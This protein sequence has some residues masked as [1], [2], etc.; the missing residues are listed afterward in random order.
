[1]P[2]ILT[3]SRAARTVGGARREALTAAPG[4]PLRVPVPPGFRWIGMVW[5]VAT[6]FS[7]LVPEGEIPMAAFRFRSRLRVA[8]VAT[9][10]LALLVTAMPVSAGGFMT[11]IASGYSLPLYVTNAGDSRLFV[12]EQRGRI[13]IIGGGT[14]LDLSGLVSQT[15]YERGLLGLAFHPD[16]ASNGRLYVNY[17]RQ[18]DG[19]TMIV[20][21][22]RSAGNPNAADPASARTVLSF[23][24][25]DA[26][27]NGGWMGFKGSNLFIS[28]GDGGDAGDGGARAQSTSYLLGKILR[29]N[30]LDPDGNG[31]KR[32][33]IPSTNPYVGISGLNEIWARGLRNPWRCSH[34]R[35]T[36]YLWCADV[37]QQKYEEINR[38]TSG[39]KLNYG[40][41]LLEGRH[42]YPSG[43]LCTSSCKTL[44]IAEYSHSAF[45]GGNCAVTGGYVSRR[46]G[47]S[48]NGRYFFGDFCSGK[49]WTIGA[50]FS[51]GGSLPS[52]TVD[53]S[54]LISS[55]GEGADGRIYLV[56][57]AGSIFLIN[58]S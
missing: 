36:G 58:G 35:G 49:V 7:W 17:T 52:P 12:V 22:T 38:S 8:L 18:S 42:R 54:S 43:A 46:S 28:S 55:F 23:A 15:G 29:I 16:Y 48:L 21:Y 6:V 27:H 37:G 57:Q 13:K 30:P 1:M 20:E 3:D 44:P 11:S 19:R 45:G 25:P 26:N 2:L 39:K 32:Y 41:A 14:F 50:G 5:S 53:T 34:D 47:A 33:S 10:L 24:Q 4:F 51:A 56:D 31:P 9:S 40:W